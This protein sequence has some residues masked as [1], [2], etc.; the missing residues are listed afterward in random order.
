[1]QH[2][3][4]GFAG[5]TVGMRYTLPWFFFSDDPKRC[6]RRTI[7]DC[8]GC[9]LSPSGCRFGR[10][11]SSGFAGGFRLLHWSSCVPVPRIR[12]C[13]DWCRYRYICRPGRLLARGGY[14]PKRSGFHLQGRLKSGRS[15]CPLPSLL[16]R[17]RK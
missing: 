14:R 8:H 12:S 4:I 5:G 10:S 7:R 15:F 11:G 6:I 9:P 1:M 17:E 3:H 13:R 16:P 2:R